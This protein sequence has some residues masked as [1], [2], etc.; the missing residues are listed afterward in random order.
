MTLGNRIAHHR[1]RLRLS[2]LELA[3]KLSVSRQSV[4]K[5]ETDAST[6]ELEK[7]VEL[8]KLF[9]LT[10]DELVTG[11]EMP[12]DAAEPAS[13]PPPSGRSTR[14]IVGLICGICGGVGTG[15]GILIPLIWVVTIPL[16]LIGLYLIRPSLALKTSWGLLF[17]P[18]VFLR[19]FTG[20]SMWTIFTLYFYQAGIWNHLLIGYVIW[21]L[22]I[23]WTVCAIRLDKTRKWRALGWGAILVVCPDWWSI[24]YWVQNSNSL[25]TL[26]ITGWLRMGVSIVVPVVVLVATLRSR[27]SKL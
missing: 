10:L 8:S 16:L 22:I 15:L 4:S 20:I 21:G 25:S 13:P 14:E 1:G 17:V 7:L 23:L 24:T 6:P 3:E 5:W 27:K 12:E 2:Q 18:L 26:P 11:V 19:Q 9:Q